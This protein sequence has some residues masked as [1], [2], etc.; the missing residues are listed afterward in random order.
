MKSLEAW[1]YEIECAVQAIAC[2]KSDREYRKAVENGRKLLQK[3][4]TELYYSLDFSELR[5]LCC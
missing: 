4:P 1:N 3:I 5:D 2:P